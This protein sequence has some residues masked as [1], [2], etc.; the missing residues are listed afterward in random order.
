MHIQP[1]FLSLSDLLANRLFRIPQYQRSYS[2]SSKERQ[3]MFEDV[4]RLRNRPE[5]RHF[6]A[7]VVGLNRGLKTII[8]DEYSVIEVVDG[9]QRLTTL[10]VLMK[11]I[12]LCCGARGVVDAVSRRVERRCAARTRA[13]PVV[14]S[15]GCC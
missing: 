6:M 7:T 2:W 10:I 8:T 11:A 4:D 13:D 12:Q 9:Q 5:Q 1:K 3:D 14:R 15:L